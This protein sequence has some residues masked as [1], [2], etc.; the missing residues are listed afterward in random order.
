MG[1]AHVTEPAPVFNLDDLTGTTVGRYK[2]R[3]RLSIGGQGE[4]YEADDPTLKRSVAIKRLTARLRQDPHYKQELLKEAERASALNHTSVA[5]VYDAFEERDEFFIVMEYVEGETLR[6]RLQKSVDLEEFYQIATQ[7][8]SGLSEAHSKGIVHRDVKPENIMLASDG[9]VKVLDFG[10]AKRL[11]EG[12]DRSTITETD[13]GAFGS[14]AGTLAYMAPEVL[15]DGRVDARSDIF[16]L[17]VVFYE[18]LTGEHP[19]RSRSHT[20]TVDRILHSTPAPI[21]RTNSQVTEELEGIVEKM[22][23]KDPDARY[24][25]TLDLGADLEA[26]R[27]GKPAVHARAAQPRWWQ[28]VRAAATGAI[29]T[30]AALV[31]L[32]ALFIIIFPGSMRVAVLPITIVD[33]ESTDRDVARANGLTRSL[34]SNLSEL[35]PFHEKLL[36]V[37]ASEVYGNDVTTAA[38]ARKLFGVDY[39]VTGS[40]QRQGGGWVLLIDLVDADDLVL[41]DSSSLKFP[42]DF[43]SGLEELTGVV[44][45]MLPLELDDEQERILLAGL[46]QNPQAM[47][48][49][50]EGQGYMLRYE[51]PENVESA[52][53][54]F[55]AALDADTEFALGHSGL[56]EAYLAMYRFTRDAVWVEQARTAC[57]RALEL[58]P[59]SARPHICLGSLHDETGRYDEAVAEFARALEI[60]ANSDDAYRGLARVQERLGRLVDAEETYKRAIAERPSYWAGYNWL[61]AFYLHQSRYEEAADM[62]QKVAEHT[63][64]NPR[65]LSNLGVVY[66]ILQRWDEAAEA[67]RGALSRDPGYYQAYNNLATLHFQQGRF[68]EAAEHYQMALQIDDS[69]YRVWGNLG[70]SYRWAAGLEGK[71][72]EAFRKAVTG[73]EAVLAVNPNDPMLLAILA[74]YYAELGRD[75]EARRSLEK[76]LGFESPETEVFFTAALVYEQ[77]ED[78]DLALA[79]LQRA[80]DLGWPPHEV[81]GHPALAELREDDRFEGLLPRED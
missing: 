17:G 8:A 7:T 50:I 10:V 15:L 70:S 28:K 1:D 74:D 75:D 48:Y 81:A 62:F 35:E 67:Y 71:A 53:T 51:D 69:D 5:G 63:P 23:S 44:A 78:R 60:K 40:L 3:R 41:R 59:D 64:D 33:S 55:R 68:I 52:V 36:V 9:T 73:A 30:A 72:P 19:F 26:L 43:F 61:G 20:A 2:I 12:A 32:Y 42:D 11:P 56:G 21:A 79:N 6:N 24:E 45:R 4:V 57:A 38:Q 54:S 16:S 66:T 76:A 49:Y 22:L 25:T 27:R 47:D 39:V 29:V 31:V 13:A 46:S 18:T 37:S 14:F 80:V 58:G 34:T 65:G 77:L